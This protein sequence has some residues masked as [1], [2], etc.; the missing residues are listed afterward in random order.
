[1]S[2]DAE[3]VMPALT[4]REAADAYNLR[5]WRECLAT[6]DAIMRE[7]GTLQN[8]F[9][10]DAITGERQ[11]WEVKLPWDDSAALPV[12]ECRCR[13]C[14]DG[15]GYQPI[16]VG[17][18]PW[19]GRALPLVCPCCFRPSCPRAAWHIYGCTWRDESGQPESEDV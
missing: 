1:M 10:A 18:G 14:A 11:L 7:P 4:E 17:S 2:D 15:Q 9:L 6:E 16:L 5:E 13:S 3:N 12:S 8:L 19:T